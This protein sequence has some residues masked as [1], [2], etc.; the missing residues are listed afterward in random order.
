MDMRRRMH[1]GLLAEAVYTYSKSIDD[2]AALGGGSLGSLAQNWLNLSGERGPSSFDQR[3]TV[4]ITLQ[5]TTGMGVRG[6][7]LLSGWRGQLVKG[8][9]ILD[10]INLGT[11]LPFTPFSTEIVPGG[12]G[13]A[14]RADYTGAPLYAA[15]GGYLLNPAAVAAPAAGQWGDAGRDSMRGPYQ[16]SMNAQAQRSFRIKERYDLQLNI[17]ASNP[18]NHPMVTG[19]YT[20]VNPQFGLPQNVSGMR[21]VATYLRLTF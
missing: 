8:W 13:G 10:G 17:T 14:V 19:V 18:L 1:N 15:P 9:T 6:G 16:F 5:Y 2:A 3:H 20:T 11:G 12:I 4:K 21:S 7:S